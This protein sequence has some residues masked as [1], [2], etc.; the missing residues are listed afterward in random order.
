[1]VRYNEPD[2]VTETCDTLHGDVGVGVGECRL[3]LR[4]MVDTHDHAL[5]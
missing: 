2:V 1:M 4:R 3:D 5:L